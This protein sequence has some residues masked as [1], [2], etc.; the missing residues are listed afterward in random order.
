[1]LKIV[2]NILSWISV[3]FFKNFLSWNLC[4]RVFH[5]GF[6]VGAAIL[7]IFDCFSILTRA[8]E[9]F[10]LTCYRVFF[11]FSPTSKKKNHEICVK[12]FVLDLVWMFT[13]NLVWGRSILKLVWR[14]TRE[15][16]GSAGVGNSLLSRRSYPFPGSERPVPGKAPLHAP[17]SPSWT[18]AAIL[19]PGTP[20]ADVWGGRGTIVVLRGAG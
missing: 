7:L 20:R 1:M 19:S 8:S 18:S 10:F 14:R 17:R 13:L 4:V 12:Y 16:N 6:S 2:L 5:L 15:R 9:F 11:D 3:E